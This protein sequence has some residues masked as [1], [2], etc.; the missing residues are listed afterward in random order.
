MIDQ[1][2][3]GLENCTFQPN[4][5]TT[6]FKSGE[7]AFKRSTSEFYNDMIRF[8]AQ[9]EKRLE[10]C[11]M[12]K[13]EKEKLECTQNSIGRSKSRSGMPTGQTKHDINGEENLEKST[14][15][16]I[17]ERLFSM[18]IKNAKKNDNKKISKEH[19]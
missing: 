5:S 10:K 7:T 8:K 9:K 11:R 4:L 19:S 16:D 18:N 15:V 3:D 13:E 2:D 14:S 6:L 1:K 17:H 12:Q